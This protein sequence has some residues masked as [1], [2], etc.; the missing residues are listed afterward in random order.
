MEEDASEVRYWHLLGLLLSATEKWKQAA[1]VLE[2]GAD[3]DDASPDEAE[4]DDAKTIHAA[5][6]EEPSPAQSFLAST[7]ESSQTT[8]K[9]QANGVATHYLENGNGNPAEEL[10]EILS[11]SLS[12]VLEESAT[13]IPPAST[14][15]RPTLSN[16]HLA[17]HEAFEVSL[18]L[19]MTQAAL[20]EVMEGPEGAEL[21]WVEVFAWIADKKKLGHDRKFLEFLLLFLI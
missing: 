5:L 20:T 1:A 2:H 16:R 17:K 10:S 15:L 13:E 6:D 12:Y 7:A 19:R 11:P 3:L 14:L 21:K 18:Q 4:Q 9:A 8:P